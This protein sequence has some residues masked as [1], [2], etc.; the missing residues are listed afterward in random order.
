MKA[1]LENEFC[2]YL[3]HQDEL[4]KKYKGKFVVIKNDKVLGAFNSRF[5]AINTIQK[6]HEL[7]T[8]LVHQ[9]EPGE[10]NYT[11]TFHSR[12]RFA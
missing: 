12:I 9:C 4:V 1:L 2:Y 8:F 3:K 5:E 6:D 10:N 11:Q 7:G